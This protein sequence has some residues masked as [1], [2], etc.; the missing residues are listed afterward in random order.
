M[1]SRL[2]LLKCIPFVVTPKD[3]I[4]TL[5]VIADTVTDFSG[6]KNRASD[7]ARS[8]FDNIN[9]T[10]T[11]NDVPAKSNAPFTATITFNENVNRF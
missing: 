2:F 1:I 10:V 8:A 3:E 5:R 11:I 4:V 6:Q 7:E 9:P